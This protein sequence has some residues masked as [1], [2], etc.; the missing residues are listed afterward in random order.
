[1]HLTDQYKLSR[2]YRARIGRA[3]NKFLKQIEI[4]KIKAHA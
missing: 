3:M 1:V 4:I 2:K